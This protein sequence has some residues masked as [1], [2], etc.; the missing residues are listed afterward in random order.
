MSSKKDI[1]DQEI[2]KE[3]ESND[4]NSQDGNTNTVSEEFF[5]NEEINTY[6]AIPLSASSPK[7]GETR[8]VLTAL[9]SFAAILTVLLT[10]IFS[11]A[12]I[13]DFII[14][15]MG[16]G[17]MIM[18]RIFGKDISGEGLNLC[19]LIIKNSFIAP[20]EAPIASPPPAESPA[21]SPSQ[22]SSPIE[23]P[24]ETPK[25]SSTPI[26]ESSSED[27][28]EETLPEGMIPIL[29]MDM[30]M[31]SYGKNYIYNT[32]KFSPNISALSS[33]PIKNYYRN[34]APIVL[35]IHTHATESY[36]PE[37]AKF[38]K[39]EGEIARSSDTNENMIA[40]GI[41][42]VRVLEENGISTLHCTVMHDK[43]S[44]RESYSRAAESIAKYLKQYPS[45][46]YVFDLHR[47]SVMRS[48][49]ELIRAV[50]SV[51]GENYAQIM[52]VIGGGADNWEENMSF[53]LKLREKLN[54][55]MTNLCRP[56]CLRESKYNQDMAAI[57]ILLEIGTSGNSLSEAKKAASVT[58][59]TIA[60][61]IK[62]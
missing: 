3:N 2:I 54:G 42:F 59:A 33:A 15:D 60:D 55:E 9:Y 21:P 48:S 53:A 45:I 30:S 47:D 52:P 34:N 58:A 56:I 27:P 29:P 62:N 41:E 44:Y 26:E 17:N 31:L 23:T 49:G 36:M 11:A 50:A 13:H 51:G 10:I 35:V 32:T 38:Y 24:P 5:D 14:K 43:E 18:K 61:L 46:K 4:T 28:P 57:S 7:K 1:M 6:D 37:G 39:D 8:H 40:V 20:E 19:E 12:E 16:T 25:E 22:P